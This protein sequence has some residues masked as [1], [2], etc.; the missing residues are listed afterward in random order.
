MPTPNFKVYLAISG[1]LIVLFL[2]VVL[3]PFGKKSIN[4]QQSTISNYPSPTSVLLPPNQLPNQNPSS[5]PISPADF[6]GVAEEELPTQVVDASLQK[7]DLRRSVPLDT[8]LFQITFDYAEDKFT[9][10]LAEPKTEN[11]A[12]FDQWRQTNY[13]AIDISQFNFK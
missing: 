7:Q 8:G 1:V 2:F 3:A 13:P 5:P 11:R 4:N 9:V 10:T 12:Q 6:T